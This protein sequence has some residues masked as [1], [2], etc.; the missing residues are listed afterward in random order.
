MGPK[1]G[2]EVEAGTRMLSALCLFSPLCVCVPLLP[3]FEDQRPQLLQN[4]WQ[5][6]GSLSAPELVGVQ[7]PLCRGRPI[8]LST[9]PMPA[10]RE[11]DV[12]WPALG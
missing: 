10:L 6:T 11:K 5:S 3:P 9:Y 4:V 2:H 1:G 12:Y 8:S 7:G